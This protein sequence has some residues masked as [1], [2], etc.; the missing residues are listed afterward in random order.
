MTGSPGQLAQLH[1]GQTRKRWCGNG[2]GRDGCGRLTLADRLRLQ[3]ATADSGCQAIIKAMDGATGRV[4]CRVCCDDRNGN[5][6]GD[7]LA[8]G[9]MVGGEKVFHGSAW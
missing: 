9:A 3:L 6:A 4:A 1:N 5:R 7:A 8:S 2:S